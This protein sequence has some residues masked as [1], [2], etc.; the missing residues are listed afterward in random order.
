M[1]TTQVDDGVCDCFQINTGEQHSRE[2]TL[3]GK[4]PHFSV[5]MASCL[6]KGNDLSDEMFEGNY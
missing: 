2:H 6:L 5:L 3:P 4:S 1:E